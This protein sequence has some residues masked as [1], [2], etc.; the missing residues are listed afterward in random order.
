MSQFDKLVNL[1]EFELDERRRE[2][3]DLLGEV[4]GLIAEQERLEEQLKKE[5][6]IASQSLE[7]RFAYGEFANSVI[8]QRE[9]LSAALRMKEKEYESARERVLLA[10]QEKQKAEIVR[11]EAIERENQKKR[12][13]EQAEID[14]IA[15]N[16]HRRKTKNSLD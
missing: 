9:W 12:L 6:Q 8:R 15:Q 7:A 4:N 16:I 11:E 3:G 14:E 1:R 13:I 2:S 5:Q 10:Y